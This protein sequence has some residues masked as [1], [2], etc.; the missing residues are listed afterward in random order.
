MS[1]VTERAEGEMF[2]MSALKLEQDSPL[3]RLLCEETSHRY[4]MCVYSRVLLQVLLILCL[5]RKSMKYPLLV[6]F[7]LFR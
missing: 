4:A 6:P 1:G 3:A 5:S 7:P 2:K